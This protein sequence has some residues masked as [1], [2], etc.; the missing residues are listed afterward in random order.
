MRW[1]PPLGV[2]RRANGFDLVV[3]HELR[4]HLKTRNAAVATFANVLGAGNLRRIARIRYRVKDRLTG[5]PWRPGH[6][7]AGFYQFK[8]GRSGGAIKGCG[9]VFHGLAFFT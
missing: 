8:F 1:D 6:V 3:R 9:L 2:V 5:Q 4:A 7:A